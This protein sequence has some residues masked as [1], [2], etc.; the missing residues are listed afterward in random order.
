MDVQAMI[1]SKVYF[2]KYSLTRQSLLPCGV[3]RERRDVALCQE[4]CHLRCSFVGVLKSPAQ[5]NGMYHLRDSKESD[6]L[7][8]FGIL[9]RV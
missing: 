4:L 6:S 3:L 2:V 5:K 1:I 7:S 9:N 8:L